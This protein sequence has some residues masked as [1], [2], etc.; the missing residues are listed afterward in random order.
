MLLIFCF[1]LISNI[2][3]A[4]QF[5]Q[6]RVQYKNHDWYYI[7][8][9]HFDI[10]FDQN[11]STIAEF[12]AHAAEDAV[13]S[14][15]KILNYKINNRISLIVY[16]SHNDFQETNTTDSYIG[17][18]TGGFT[19]PFKNRVVFPFEGDY[20]KYR[21]VIHHELVHGV[22]R[23]MLYGGTVQNI[24][25]KGITLQLP[26]WYHEG[27][28]EYLSSGWETNTDMFIRD[29]IIN[30]YLPDINQLNGYFAYRGGQA[31]FRYIA[32]KYGDE[33]IGELLGKIQG[34]GNVEEG[35]KSTIGLD[36]EELNDRWKKDIK[37]RYWPEI[38]ERKDPEV[39][40]KRITDNE[41]VGGFY[42]TS[43]ALSPQGD[44]VVFIS[45][46]DIFLDIYIMDLND[47]DEAEKLIESGRTNDFE[48]LNVLFPS[49][50]WAPDN[51]RIAFSVK[52]SGF[53]R[54]V[55]FDTEEEESIELPLKLEGIESVAWSPDGSKIA[56]NGNDANQSDIYYYDL[57]KKNLVN[58]TNDIFSDFDPSW[59]PLSDMILFASDRGEYVNQNEIDEN[60]I[61]YEHNYKQLDLYSVKIQSAKITRITD[62]EYSDEKSAVVS[63]KGDEILFVSDK[64]G[65][66]NLYRKKI[67]LTTTDTISSVVEIPAYPLTNSLN[68]INQLST[69][70][71]GKKLLFTSLYDKG[72]NIYQI[73]NPF[74]AKPVADDL[75]MTAYMKSL[76]YP[77]KY[78]SNLLATEADK[79][80]SVELMVD[81]VYTDSD[82]LIVSKYAEPDS[83][84]SSSRAQIF[85]GQYITKES[86]QDSTEQDYSNY[87]F[88]EHSELGDSLSAVPREKIFKETLDSDGNYLVNKYKISFSPDLIYANAGYSTLYGLLGTTVL[89]FSDMLGNHRLIG[90]T[91]L[92]ID[93]KNSD[94]G[95][96]YYYLKQRTNYGFEGFHTARFVY[97]SNRF[98]RSLY[99]FRNY[100]GVV[101]AS[102]PIS[103]F[104]RI[105]ASMSLLNLSSENLDNISVPI[106]KETYIIPSVSFVHDNT[107]FGYTSPIEGTRFNLTLFGNPG[108]NNKNKSFYS[109]TWDWRDYTRFW[110]DNSIVLRFSGGY[111]GGANPQRFFL[112]GTESWINR[113]WSSGDIP[114]EDASDFAFLTP[115]LPLRGYN[116]AERIGTKYSLV[117]M[118]F[119]FPFIRYL[120]TGGLPLFFQNILGV[121]FI[122]MGS[123]WD[124]T[125]KLKLFERNSQGKTVTKDLLAATGVGMRLY[126]LFLWR[127]D[128][129]WTFDYQHFS[130][131]RYYISLGWD[132]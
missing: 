33:K 63:T 51:K 102:Y 17:Q 25:A 12:A 14:I 22:M 5:G 88:G 81:S 82:V 76:V 124:K 113:S 131:P 78:D 9:K 56:F 23:D 48:E 75:P 114:L 68:G 79:D 11:G 7:Q 15:Q 6:N 35:F 132:F 77:D 87:I 55:I 47:P 72:Y 116:Y 29:A 21:H 100:G 94:Y 62:W 50:T 43:P 32:E 80:S 54:I 52:S 115:A 39:F 3:Y 27:M 13:E 66:D 44:K 69:S 91:S 40:A 99:R 60:F 20:K 71:D 28:A 120:V 110:F 95:L 130:K 67:E 74:E 92:Q 93:L 34:I 126:M 8:T 1:A 31:L 128:V 109:F 84:D 107:L 57:E 111:S 49:L 38:A 86:G 129:A 117:N 104:Y 121:A 65:I 64:N 37:I 16:D 24:I 112:G 89:S 98:G 26:I 106:D 46:R 101:S 119:R 83:A 85:A 45:D 108:I 2:I 36:L 103:R 97:L 70:R 61:M 41:K 30:E 58:L 123:A 118:E 90:V 127:F 18:G 42:N 125:D 96:A 53:D 4:Q 73:N 59:G 122:D 105:D 19:E 10:Y